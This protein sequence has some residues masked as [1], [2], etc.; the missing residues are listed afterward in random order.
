MKILQKYN[1]LFKTD[2]KDLGQ[3]AGVEHRIRT[4]RCTPIAQTNFRILEHYKKDIDWEI[5][6]YLDTG[7]IKPS[8]SPWRSRVVPIRKPDGYVRLCI[9]YRSLNSLTKTDSYTIPRIDEVI[10]SLSGAKI[11]S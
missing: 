5:Q 3:I 10:D 11:F 6:K 4:Q 7:I 1:K 2:I 8:N 9:D